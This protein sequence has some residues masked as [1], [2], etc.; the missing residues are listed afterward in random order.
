[1]HVTA[2]TQSSLPSGSGGLDMY[3]D[4]PPFFSETASVSRP[5][6]RPIL[7]FQDRVQD[8]LRHFGEQGGAGMCGE[9]EKEVAEAFAL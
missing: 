3:A 9:L 7:H 6:G 8:D 2:C 1:M 4:R 5:R